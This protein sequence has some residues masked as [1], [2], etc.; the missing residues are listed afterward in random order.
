MKRAFTVMAA[1]VLMA[2]TLGAAPASASGGANLVAP[3]NA[4][5][6][7]MTY[8][9]WEAAYQIWIEEIPLAQNP[10]ADPA[11]PRNCELQPGNTVFVGASGA[12]C[13][14]P[15]GAAIGLSTYY[16][17]C[18]TAEGLG[19]TYRALRKCAEENFVH[20]FGPQ[21]SH[22]T[23]RID[24]AKV[25]HPL[26][27]TFTTPG[28]IIHFP[29][30]NLWGATPGPSKSVTRGLMFII[31]SLADGVHHIRLHVN[32]DVFGK[33]NIDYTLHVG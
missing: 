21:V 29:T 3:P 27:W 11:S 17:E 30:N 28:E 33:F 20:D 4:V 24:G 19:N 10:Q 26:R 32:H 12:D 18:S 14:V 5:R 22:A 2:A 23:L 1:G 7:G 16:W 6:H 15:S 25:N 31:R 8:P 9:E 13:A